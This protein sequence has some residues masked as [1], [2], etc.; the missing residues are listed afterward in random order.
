M[1]K[2]IGLLVAIE[3]DAI[4]KHYSKYEELEAPKGFKAYKI[5]K[6]NATLYVLKC[7]MGECAASAGTQ[8]LA[9]KYNVEMIINFGVVGGL[10]NDMRKHKICVVER[11]VHYK[12]DCSE[13]LDLSVGQVD[14]HDSIYLK[15]DENLLEKALNANKELMKVTCCSGD[16]FISTMEEKTY[17]HDTFNGDICDMESSGIVL[18]SEMNDIPCLLLKAVSDGLNDGSNGFFKELESASLNCLIVTDK[19]IDS[20]K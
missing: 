19:I 13:F 17:L 11:V 3:L 6:D 7:G 1:K 14:G 16:K 2:R 8:L 4:F 5:E 9:S 15:T 18:T 12:Y 20:L 10:T